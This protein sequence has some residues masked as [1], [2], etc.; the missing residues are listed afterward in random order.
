MGHQLIFILSV[1]SENTQGLP[2]CNVNRKLCLQYK[3]E[4][5]KKAAFILSHNVP[6]HKAVALM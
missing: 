3:P 6:Q 4:P 5:L 2:F 1:S